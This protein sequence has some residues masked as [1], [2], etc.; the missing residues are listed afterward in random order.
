MLGR[1]TVVI[2]LS[3]QK[4][5]SLNWGMNRHCKTRPDL[6]QTEFVFLNSF[7]SVLIE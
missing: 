6:Y 7:I 2:H 5:A 1:K 3:V 4:M